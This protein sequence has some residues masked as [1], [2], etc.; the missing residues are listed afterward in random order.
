M[1]DVP[2][3]QRLQKEKMEKKFFRFLE[4]FKNIEINLPFT[5]G[6]IQMPNYAK[7]LKDILSKKRKFAE[8]G[9]VNLTATCNVVIMRSLPEKVQDPGRFTISCTL[10]ILNSRR[11]YVTPEIAST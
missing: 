4:V 5:E 11:L 2:F 10:G 8:E 3:P 9:V 7:F 6:L 1:L